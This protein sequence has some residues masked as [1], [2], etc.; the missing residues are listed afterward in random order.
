[1]GKDNIDF[2]V[3]G[4][5]LASSSNSGVG[6]ILPF[7]GK[8]KEMPSLFNKENETQNKTIQ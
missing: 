7:K 6:L 2:V 8:E 5:E 3:D 4:F 1:M